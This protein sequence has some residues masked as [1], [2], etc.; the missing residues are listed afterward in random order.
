MA[1]LPPKFP[2]NTPTISP[3]ALSTVSPP[4]LPSMSSFFVASPSDVPADSSWVDEFFDFNSAKRGSHRRAISDSITFL[5]QDGV[6]ADPNFDRIDDDQLIMSMF[7]NDPQPSSTPP[8]D[9]QSIFEQDKQNTT[10]ATSG[11]DQSE[12]QSASNNAETPLVGVAVKPAVTSS[13]AKTPRHIVDPKRVKRILANRQSAQRS[14][15]RKLQYIVDLEKNV[16]TL[17]AEIAVLKPQVA[18]IDQRRSAL[19]AGNSQLKQRIAALAQDK[20][21]KDAQTEAL[22]K[23]VERLQQIYYQQ[24]M[25]AVVEVRSNGRP[26]DGDNMPNIPADVVNNPSTKF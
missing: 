19:S 16:A 3:D 14:R 15:V 21:F 6:A 7:S 11:V 1:Q 13:A 10:N 23:E 22:K 25:A 24:T 8:S 5:S 17:E 9:Q 12:E 4:R 18:S 2:S 20:I 26:V